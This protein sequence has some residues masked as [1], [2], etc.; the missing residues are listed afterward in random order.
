LP[1]A[2]AFALRVQNRML[3]TTNFGR[4]KTKGENGLG[5]LVKGGSPFF[6]AGLIIW[7]R[8]PQKR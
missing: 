2:V 4:T 6:V 1:D 5:Q 8:P 3:V 7:R